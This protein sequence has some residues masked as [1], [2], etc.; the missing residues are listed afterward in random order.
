MG[1]GGLT[2]LERG[3]LQPP[4]DEFAPAL[5]TVAGFAGGLAD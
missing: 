5:G 1:S 2:G 4:E 3:G